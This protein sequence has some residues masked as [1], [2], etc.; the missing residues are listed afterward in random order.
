ML[1]VMV[2]TDPVLCNATELQTAAECK[3]TMIENEKRTLDKTQRLLG[4][5]VLICI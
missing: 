1:C 2:S 3:Y 4:D 5:F